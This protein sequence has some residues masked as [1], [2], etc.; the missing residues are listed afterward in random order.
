[1]LLPL[2]S[3]I[4]LLVNIFYP[5][6]SP[7]LLLPT[8]APH[9]HLSY[10]PPLLLISSS[11][12]LI[13]ASIQLKNRKSLWRFVLRN[14]FPTTTVQ[15]VA[16]E[17]RE[18]REERSEREES[19]EQRAESKENRKEG[20]R[21]EREGRTQE[22]AVKKLLSNS[23]SLLSFLVGPRVRVVILY[24]RIAWRER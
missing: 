21:D 24:T 13:F 19:R 7:S 9:L 15:K 10:S 1:M 16:R 23:Y 6:S 4:S 20:R 5:P 18:K 12:P 8:S 11:F 3:L 14:H 17:R 2:V 22:R